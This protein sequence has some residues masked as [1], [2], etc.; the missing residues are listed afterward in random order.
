[1]K[2]L[3]NVC[4]I[5][6]SGTFLCECLN[7]EIIQSEAEIL[8]H[9]GSNKC[10]FIESESNEAVFNMITELAESLERFLVKVIRNNISNH[11]I[12]AL[13]KLVVS[14][15]WYDAKSF[16]DKAAQDTIDNGQLSI[17]KVVQKL[18][19]LMGNDPMINVN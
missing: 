10:E 7:E 1:M 16:D 4:L 3:E 5:E 2:N 8:N 17:A 11:D 13:S 18:Q 19:D 15:V 14:D 6:A 9:I 12:D